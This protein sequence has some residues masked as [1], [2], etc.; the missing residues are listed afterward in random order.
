MKV[1]WVLLGVVGYLYVRCAM[2]PKDKYLTAKKEIDS[3]NLQDL[4]CIAEQGNLDVRPTFEEL[5]G[6]PLYRIF[7]QTGLWS[8]EQL[9]N[10]LMH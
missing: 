6:Q 4:L 5:A 2:T 1:G 10:R 9:K 8:F 3:V 7:G